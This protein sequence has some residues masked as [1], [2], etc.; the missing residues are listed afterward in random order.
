MAGYSKTCQGTS[1]SQWTKL[2]HY[3]HLVSYPPFL[4]PK[5]FPPRLPLGKRGGLERAGFI[6]FGS[7]FFTF[8]GTGN[9]L[10]SHAN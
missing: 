1:G 4:A 2:P 3:P 6:F 7:Y 5:Q 8:S 10:N 9:M